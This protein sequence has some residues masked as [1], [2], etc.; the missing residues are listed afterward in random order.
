MAA[1]NAAALLSTGRPSPLE[2][3]DAICRIASASPASALLRTE[4]G[5]PWCVLGCVYVR[6]RAALGDEGELRQPPMVCVCDG[7]C[8]GV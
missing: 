2:K 3:A 5:T 7:V 8:D 6:R 4:A 1:H